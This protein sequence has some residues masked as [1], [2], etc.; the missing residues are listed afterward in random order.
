MRLDLISDGVEHAAD[1]LPVMQRLLLLAQPLLERL[2]VGAERLRIGQRLFELPLPVVGAVHDVLLA[3]TQRRQRRLERDA[4]ALGALGDERLADA[5][6][7]MRA[8]AVVLQLLERL[9]QC[10]RHVIVMSHN[11]RKFS[12]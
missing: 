8:R 12:I 1:G 3:L 5:Q 2:H 7:R 11:F 9:L 4:G 6:Q 10:A